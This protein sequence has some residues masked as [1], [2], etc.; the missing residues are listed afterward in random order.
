MSQTLEL[1]CLDCKEHLWIG[2][3]R[4]AARPESAYVY[5]TDE[6]HQHLN[7]FVRRHVGHTLKLVDDEGFDMLDAH[8]WTDVESIS[9]SG[10]S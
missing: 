8:D 10:E 7:A 4:S 2:Q 3:R 5:F 1:C 6:A 9:S